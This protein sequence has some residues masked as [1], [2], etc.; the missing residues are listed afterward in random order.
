MLTCYF[1][2]VLML[3]F[4]AENLDDL[5]ACPYYLFQGILSFHVL[6]QPAISR[7][8]E[9]HFHGRKVPTTFYHWNHTE[10]L[11]TPEKMTLKN[12]IYCVSNPDDLSFICQV[13][14][15]ERCYQYVHASKECLS[16][17]Y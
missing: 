2:I 6:F 13:K 16:F 4:N 3:P 15:T 5:T 11:T 8:Q 12:W 7:L 1:I 10:G 9:S 17:H 14:S